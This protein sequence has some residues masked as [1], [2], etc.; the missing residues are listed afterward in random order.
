MNIWKDILKE[1][2]GKINIQSFKTWLKPT[3]QLKHTD[4]FLIVSVPSTVFKD[5]INKTYLS[6]IKKTLKEMGKPELEIKFI[7]LDEKIKTTQED[8]SFSSLLNPK[9]TFESFV[10]GPSNRFSHAAAM[11][12]SESPFDSY[13]PLFIYGGAGLGKTH[14]I[15]AIGHAILRKTKNIKL[16]FITSEKFMNELV[17]AIRYRKTH[18]F[19]EKYRNIDVL[20]IDDIQFIAGKDQTE[21][22]FFHTF[23]TLYES[24][25]QITITSDC[26]PKEIPIL[27][28][29]LRSRFE[30]GLIADIKPP[31]L[32]TKMAILKKKADIQGF[33]NFPDD[34][35][36]FIASKVKSNVREL[37]G[38]LTSLIAHSS[39]YGRAIDIELARE[40][41]ANVID[42]EGKIITVKSIQK[43]IADKYGTTVKKLKSKD[44][45][46]AVAMPRHIAMYLSRELTNQS[47]PDIG[48]KF[49]KDHS[50]VVYACNKVK[51]LTE[52]RSDFKKEINNLI[53]LLK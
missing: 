38:C 51:K 33:H 52:E 37:E 29:R 23:N 21:E 32:E 5:W 40:V 11:A 6:E 39:L 12:V 28:E 20:L 22:E 8:N 50:S 34:V 46:H 16:K 7:A 36:L 13:N 31:D 45:S 25:K 48:K 9:S 42:V 30:W 19:R 4:N 15:H 10:T 35:S 18:E 1:L 3:K 14:L 2:E 44:N 49:G 53:E 47:F 26:P 17:N 41:L 43:T 27:E 24:Q